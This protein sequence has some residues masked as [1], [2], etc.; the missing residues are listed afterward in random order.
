MDVDGVAV[1][2]LKE[3]RKRLCGIMVTALDRVR[4]RG[5]ERVGLLRISYHDWIRDAF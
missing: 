4:Q 5:E 3:N 2:G 1:I